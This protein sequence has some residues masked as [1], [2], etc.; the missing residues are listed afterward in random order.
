MKKIILFFIIFSILPTNIAHAYLDPG[1]GSM[2]LQIFIAGIV[3]FTY[4]VIAY[5]NKIGAFFK[6]F[7]KK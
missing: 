1:S 4:T 6:K 3:S 7:I 5:W 2:F